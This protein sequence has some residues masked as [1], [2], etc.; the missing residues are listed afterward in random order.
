MEFTQSDTASTWQSQDLNR[1][2]SDFRS[3]ALNQ[4]A[5]PQT[6]LKLTCSFSPYGHGSITQDRDPSTLDFILSAHGGHFGSALVQGHKQTDP[7]SPTYF[8][9]SLPYP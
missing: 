1:G 7:Q 2:Q 3:C 5:T 6:F 8:S 4:C 9:P